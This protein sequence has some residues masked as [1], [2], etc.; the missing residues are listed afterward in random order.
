MPSDE[1]TNLGAESHEGSEAVALRPDADR[2]LVG[3]TPLHG[4]AAAWV[5]IAAFIGMAIAWSNGALPP[6]AGALIGGAVVFV[7]AVFW[8]ASHEPA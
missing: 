4:E 7:P 1:E 8:I 6:W 2:G 3:P 5:F